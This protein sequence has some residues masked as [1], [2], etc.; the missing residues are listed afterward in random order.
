MSKIDGSKDANT[1]R[2]EEYA[3]QFLRIRGQLTDLM[4]R[5]MNVALQPSFS[6]YLALLR[7]VRLMQRNVNRTLQELSAFPII[8]QESEDTRRNREQ[9]ESSVDTL[10]ELELVTMELFRLEDRSRDWAFHKCN[11]VNLI[12]V[13]FIIFQCH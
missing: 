13:F 12:V 11:P 3:R 1:A 10:R 7:A 2:D 9:M 6:T 5:A 4:Q 8:G